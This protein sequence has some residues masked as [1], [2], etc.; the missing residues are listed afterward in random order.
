MRRDV[1]KWLEK[2]DKVHEGDLCTS[3]GSPERKETRKQWIGLFNMCHMCQH[4]LQHSQKCVS[5]MSIKINRRW[6][7]P[8]W[9]DLHHTDQ[10]NTWGWTE[11]LV[12]KS[13]R[14]LFF[15]TILKMVNMWLNTALICAVFFN[16][17]RTIDYRDSGNSILKNV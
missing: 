13:H 17:W 3:D 4:W 11:M 1:L 5:E 16:S 6:E 2:K 8:S 9:V 14:H 7:H 15:L 10:E 12:I